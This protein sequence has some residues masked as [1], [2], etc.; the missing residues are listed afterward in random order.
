MRVYLRMPNRP[1][2]PVHL[3]LVPKT[4]EQIDYGGGRYVVVSVVH[5]VESAR[6]VLELARVETEQAFRTLQWNEFG[7]YRTSEIASFAP[8]THSRFRAAR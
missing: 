7:R 2:T 5:S 1:E 3:N 8:A 6:T 4:G